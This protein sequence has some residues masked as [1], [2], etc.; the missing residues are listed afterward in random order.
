MQ[1]DQERHAGKTHGFPPH[2]IVHVCSLGCVENQLDGVRME[3][4]FAANGWRLSEKPQEADLVLVNS[5]GYTQELESSSLAALE[6]LRE[7]LK[8]GAV[9][10]LVGC[11]PAI[12]PQAADS[13]DGMKIIPRHLAA[14]NELIHAHVP[15]EEVEANTLPQDEEHRDRF[16]TAMLHLKRG[17]DLL[18]RLAPFPLPRGLRQFRYIADD[19]AYYI[20]ISVGCLGRCSFCAVRR[21]KGKL[22]SRDPQHVLRDFDQGL[23]GGF[24]DIVLSADEVGSYGRDRGTTLAHLLTEFLQR[25]GNYQIFLRNLDPEWLIKDLDHLIPLFRTGK[26][27]YIVAPVQH[28]SEPILKRMD[29][30][31]TARQAA[32]AL[33]RLHREVPDT[34]LRTHF[35]VGFPGETEEHFREMMDYAA[36]I[37]VD[38]FKVHE[39]SPRPHTRAALMEDTV[40]P[41]VILRRARRL[42]MLGLKI[43]AKSF[44]A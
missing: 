44:F 43:Y 18:E 23:A 7:I 4:F 14:L 27:P 42:K 13:G 34:I 5:C 8:P 24:R 2:P 1:R 29:R 21:A 35:I 41:A 20:K 39:F 12:H 9:I 10:H 36:A 38:H 6:Q 28:G 25:S 26:F 32:E 31:Y 19:R 11:L 37:R 17:V 33:A 40:A 15:I 22:L 30:G 16:R 3:R